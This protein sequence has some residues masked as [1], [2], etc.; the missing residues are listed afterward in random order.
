MYCPR[1]VVNYC[2]ELRADGNAFAQNYWSNTSS[3]EVVRKFIRRADIG[4]KKT[5]LKE[6]LQ[7]RL[8]KKE[9]HQEL[10]YK[11]KDIWSIS[12]NEESGDGYSDILVRSEDEEISIV[13]EV[14]YAENGKLEEAC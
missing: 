10:T 6:L 12:S 5:R 13:I 11:D 9:I 4:T 2:D 7:E 8:L 3:N 14:K 1:D